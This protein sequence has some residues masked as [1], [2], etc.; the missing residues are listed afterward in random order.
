MCIRDSSNTA[1]EMNVKKALYF[2]N[3]AQEFWLCDQDGGLRF[4]DQNG[5]LARSRLAPLLPVSIEIN[6]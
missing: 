3:G 6:H 1:E 5:E 4:F 2:N